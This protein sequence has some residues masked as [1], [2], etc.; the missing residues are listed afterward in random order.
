M[1]WNSIV[2][3]SDPCSPHRSPS[4]GNP[5]RF[6]SITAPCSG[7]IEMPTTVRDPVDLDP[8]FAPLINALLTNLEPTRCTQPTCCV[9]THV[10]FERHDQMVLSYR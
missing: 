6:P 2:G 8:S 3:G 10:R 4:P 7:W 1:S 9:S 5:F